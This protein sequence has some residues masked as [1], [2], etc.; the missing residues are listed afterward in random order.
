MGTFR[1]LF[2]DTAQSRTRKGQRS[3]FAFAAAQRTHS[4]IRLD[5]IL[6]LND[7]QFQAKRDC[8]VETGS[9]V[10]A[11]AMKKGIL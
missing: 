9:K 5:A 2:Y 11:Q 10:S 6:W 3:L 7:T 8:K 4:E 1:A